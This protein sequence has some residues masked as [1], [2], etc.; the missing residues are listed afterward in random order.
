MAAHLPTPPFLAP[1][2]TNPTEACE[3]AATAYGCDLLAE[4]LLIKEEFEK[5]SLKYLKDGFRCQRVFRDLHPQC[6]VGEELAR[7]LFEMNAAFVARDVVLYATY[8]SM[9]YYG[10]RAPDE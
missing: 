7:C 4:K 9:W 3:A 5:A 10:L 8:A 2:A 6:A 1:T